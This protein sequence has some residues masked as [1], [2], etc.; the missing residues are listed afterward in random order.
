MPIVEVNIREQSYEIRKRIADRI[1]TVLEEEAG[2][3]RHSITV[4]F[5]TLNPDYVA[6]GG[7]MVSEILKKNS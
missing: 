4:Y 2:A 6:S 7:E 5:N 1:T 3:P